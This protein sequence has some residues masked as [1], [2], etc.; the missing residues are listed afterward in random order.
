MLQHLL[1]NRLFVKAEKCEFHMETVSFL[2][3]I[4]EQG[5]IKP[6]KVRGVL[7]WSKPPDL[8]QLQCFLGLT[9]FYRSFI[10]DFSKIV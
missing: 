3:F 1:E 7:D 6:V 5:N 4:T 2:S 10:W 8:N 9:N